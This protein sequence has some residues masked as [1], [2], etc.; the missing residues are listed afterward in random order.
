ML[1][2]VGPYED[3]W[4]DNAARLGVD[5][6]AIEALFLS[7]W[8]ADHSGPLPQVVAAIAGARKAAGLAEP[9]LVSLHPDRPDQR[10]TLQ[11]NGTMVLLPPEPTFEAV[12]AAGGRVAKRAEVH[13]LCDGF[14]LGSG[15][16][17]RVTAYEQ[18]LVGH[19]TFH[20]DR[21]TSDPLILDER[22][23]ART[24]ASSTRRWARTHCSRPHRSTWCWAAITSWAG[25]WSSASTRRCV[26]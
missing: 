25:R 7:H 3:L 19:H 2:D 22:L 26:T 16:I 9:L 17:D 1:F 4:L 8:H 11:P 18:G 13:T 20:G 12:E 23:P 5:L 14:F 24:P 6:A 10:G 15:R 21:A